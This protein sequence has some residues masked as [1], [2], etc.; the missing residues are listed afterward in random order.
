MVDVFLNA[1]S[2]QQQVA[3]MLVAKAAGVSMPK[4]SSFEKLWRTLPL[5]EAPYARD[6]SDLGRS[7]G[8]GP[9]ILFSSGGS[10]GTP[11]VSQLSFDE[12]VRNSAAHGKGYKA[13]GVTSADIVATWGL[14]GLLTSEFTCYLALA[15][16][17]CCIIPIGSG[18]DPQTIVAMVNRFR[19]TVLL[20]LPSILVPVVGHLE[21]TG[22]RLSFVRLVVTGGEPLYP[23]DETRFR[24]RLNESVRFRSVFQTSEVGTLGYQCTDCVFNEYHVHDEIQLAEIVNCQSNG[25]GELVTTNLDRLERPV[26]RQ[27]TGDLA[28]RVSGKCGCGRTAPR[29]RLHGRTGRYVKIGGEKFNVSWFEKFRQALGIQIDDLKLTLTRNGDGSDQIIVYSTRLSRDAVMQKRALELLKDSS[30]K[31]A[32]QLSHGVIA[33]PIF[34]DMQP[35]MRSLT[36]AGKSRFFEDRRGSGTSLSK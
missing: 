32:V 4:E 5:S 3:A 29:I 6:A 14:P 24:A 10:T 28:E 30:S 7:K 16:T 9:C 20:V 18:V 21:M 34:K 22:E 1:V 11:K 12:V 8:Q 26:L 25:I 19:A 2:G 36:A 17:G 33:L 15:E 23:A 35:H 27:R 31:I 13:N